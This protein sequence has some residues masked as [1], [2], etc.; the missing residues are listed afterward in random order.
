MKCHSI[1][2]NLRG[3]DKVKA[4]YKLKK[5]IIKYG[6]KS[7]R[8]SSL[9]NSLI[10]KGKI[11]KE[12]SDLSIN[13]ILPSSTK[14]NN[15]I[16]INLKNKQILDN[17][18]DY[19]KE[20][21]VE[22][23]KINTKIIKNLLIEKNLK[24][25]E[26]KNNSF[27]DNSKQSNKQIL[28]NT[29]FTLN[30]NN[31]KKNDNSFSNFIQN[32]VRNFYNINKNKTCN[33][34]FNNLLNK[35]YSPINKKENNLIDKETSINKKILKNNSSNNIL[36]KKILFRN[37]NIL[38]QFR[39]MNL[40]KKPKININYKILKLSRNSSTGDIIPKNSNIKN[41]KIFYKK[42]KKTKDMKLTKIKMSKTQND[43]FE[44]TKSESYN[45]EDNL[46]KTNGKKNF[47]QQTINEN[48]PIK[49]IKFP[50]LVNINN[51]RRIPT[52]IR[53]PNINRISFPQNSF[54]S[55]NSSSGVNLDYYDSNYF[56]LKDLRNKSINKIYMI[57]PFIRNKIISDLKE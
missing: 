16:K 3:Y 29:L 44:N 31:N 52:Y 48:Y 1:K 32:S 14:Y 56:Y 42:Y 47:G 25:N 13:N 15:T 2:F 24:E 37:K 43:I 45:K 36:Y 49:R 28:V 22:D 41:R 40:G 30:N 55:E 9:L 46:N 54:K 51:Y 53:I 11:S 18:N 23:E 6:D 8:K 17:D 21:A 19:K 7:G 50:L 26:V 35:A 39:N 4:I 5:S 12:F 57:N 34:I 33:K 20:R 38:N 10:K 27:D